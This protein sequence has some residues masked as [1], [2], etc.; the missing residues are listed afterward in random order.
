M[1]MKGVAIWQNIAT[2]R[3]YIQ[4]PFSATDATNNAGG[5]KMV[6]YYDEHERVFVREQAEFAEKFKYMGEIQ[7]YA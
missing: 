3:P 2:G 4:L 6:L 7:H 1:S 5:N